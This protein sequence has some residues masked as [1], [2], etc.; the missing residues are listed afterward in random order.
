MIFLT[1]V[2]FLQ[3]FYFSIA[4]VFEFALKKT[5]NKG[6]IKSKDKRYKE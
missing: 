3:L 6:K 1:A 4:F 5:N 2:G